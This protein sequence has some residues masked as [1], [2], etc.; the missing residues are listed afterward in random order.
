MNV[1]RGVGAG[2]MLAG[3]VFSVLAA[4]GVV[5]FPSPVARLHAATKPASLGLALVTLGAGVA[6]GSW[7]LVGIAGLVAVFLFVTAPISG[8]LVGRAAY[9]AG[10]AGNL[11]YDDLAE[12]DSV[13]L[14][15]GEP[16]RGGFSSARWVGMVVVWM[17]MWRDASVGTAIGGAAVAA[18]V[19]TMRSSYPR[20]ANRNPRGLVVFFWRYAAMVLSS[21]LR[22]A[23]EVITPRNDRIREA[24]VAV[25]LQTVS[26]PA[27]LL[28][29]NAVSYSPGTLTVELTDHPM[30][31]YV[32]VLHFTTTDEVRQQVALIERLVGDAI[33]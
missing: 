12:A 9:L 1:A 6:A 3:T 5:N 16:Y 13:P 7:A 30:V 22:V 28:V 24:I 10:H 26:L 2:L 18:V 14:R 32:H 15:A 29:A 27:A 33:T 21:N 17:L 20:G 25:P 23:W 8:H 19:E 11:V 31:L 4:W